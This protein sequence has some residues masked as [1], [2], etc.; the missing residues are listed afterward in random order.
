MFDQTLVKEDNT[1]DFVVLE[2][3]MVPMRDGVRLAT[4]VYR[5]SHGSEQ[6]DNSYGGRPA[7]L[8]RTP[9]C[10]ERSP[11]TERSLLPD[12]TLTDPMDV[13][14]IAERFARR[15][16]VVVI[17]DCRGRYK[18]EGVFTKYTNE[19]EDGVDTLE[20]ICSQPW[21][22]GKVGTYGLSY[23]A[24]VQ[25]SMACLAPPGLACMFLESGGFWDAF[26]DGV[27][28]AGAFTMKQ[29]TWAFRN[30]K[31]SPEVTSN[32]DVKAQMEAMDI[33]DWFKTL[34][35]RE[36][37]SPLSLAP[38]YERYIFEDWAS[39]TF[40]ERWQRCGLYAKGFEQQIPDIPVMI[41][42]SWYDPYI[43]AMTDMYASLSNSKQGPIKMV[44]G[45]WTHGGHARTYAGDVEFGPQA[46][47]D[48]NVATTFQ[49]ARLQWFDEHVQGKP[50]GFS[51]TLGNS[52]LGMS[53]CGSPPAA[54]STMQPLGK[55]AFIG[56]ALAAVVE[57]G[58]ELNGT[59]MKVAPLISLVRST[60]SSMEGGPASS[61]RSNKPAAISPTAE[62][63]LQSRTDEFMFHPVPSVAVAGMSRPAAV[64]LLN[65][66]FQASSSTGPQANNLNNSYTTTACTAEAPVVNGTPLLL[67]TSTIQP[68]TDGANGVHD[69]HSSIVND[70][71][72][73]SPTETQICKAEK[74]SQTNGLA[75]PQHS[76]AGLAG[77]SPPG[78]SRLSSCDA[79][80]FSNSYGP[81]VHPR[82]ALVVTDSTPK[83]S[84]NSNP[85]TRPSY[86]GPNP[87]VMYFR[88]GG[89]TGE[90]LPGCGRMAHGG[91][92]MD[93]V[94]WPMPFQLKPRV[95]YL[96]QGK[97]LVQAAPQGQE[98]CSYTYTHNPQDP[99]PTIGGNI[100]SGEP[101]MSGGAYDQV[102]RLDFFGC[103]ES[104]RAL[105]DRDDVVSF[106][107]AILEGDVEIT[108]S[109][110]LELF[111][112]SNCPDTDVCV[113]LV[114]V[115]P[116]STDYPDG[117]AMN[118]CSGIRRARFRESY[119]D[120]SYLVPGQIYRIEVDLNV[121]SNLFKAGHQI[122][123]DV[124][125]SCFPRYDINYGVTREELEEWKSSD[126]ETLPIMRV[127]TNTIY[128]DA[129]HPSHIRVP[130]RK[131]SEANST[132]PGPVNEPLIPFSSVWMKRRPTWSR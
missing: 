42:C 100:T 2:H 86:R 49:G 33:R 98:G 76:G 47:F 82:P 62:S 129:A 120:P 108:G 67:S 75:I 29:V 84:V 73:D 8:H 114:D 122:R 72:R 22:N 28:H 15:G 10:K 104:G 46:T 83:K 131:V 63:R 43:G 64:S 95:L 111:I 61:S 68:T 39:D 41:I 13:T 14:E 88:M 89:G 50:G 132:T 18:S 80:S 60:R 30:A 102:E 5:P 17:Q 87:D 11:N 12:G 85:Y 106:R 70:S 93:A 125:S 16:Y 103:Y 20:W 79:S 92:W 4:D 123:L 44:L 90:R 53:P 56:R 101:V 117:F 58:E 91:Q 99:V 124:A 36:G 9:Y 78:F 23:C 32:P 24:H 69:S 1:H 118:L 48:H 7:L 107:S 113:T 26:L 38:D 37:N 97:R 3:H 109:C 116:P 57:Q 65:P 105:C 130:M 96:S 6:P 19:G 110:K 54:A 55:G 121:T 59:G 115:Y 126:A 25:L 112:S 119:T 128:C 35:W 34:P 77:T 21:S 81:T 66:T 40:S 45:P 74:H 31:V 52:P 127:A 51:P 94:S 27:R 71:T